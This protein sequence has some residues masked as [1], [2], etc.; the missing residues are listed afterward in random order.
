M[1]PPGGPR[2]VTTA[3]IQA[4][5]PDSLRA[6]PCLRV[7]EMPSLRTY[8]AASAATVALLL[9]ILAAAASI[10]LANLGNRPMHCDEAVHGIKFGQLLEQDTYIYDPHEYHGPSLNYLTLPVAWITGAEEIVDVSEAHLR[11][12]P[13]F[14][15]ILLVGLVWLLRHEMGSVAMLSAA[16]LTAFSPAMVFFSRYYIQEMLLVA[17]T[18]LAIV[19]LGRWAHLLQPRPVEVGG[20]PANSLRALTLPAAGWLALF[21]LAVAMMHASKETCVLALAAMLFAGAVTLPQVRRAGWKRLVPSI[22]FAVAVGAAVSAAFFSS[23]GKNPSG[24]ADSYSTYFHYLGQ[25]SGEGSVGRHVQPWHY[26]F[27]N[28]FWWPAEP[29]RFWSEGL[30]AALAF[31]GMVAAVVGKA[32]DDRQRR[33]ARFLAMYTVLLTVVYAALPYKTPWCSLSFLSGMILLAGVGMAA[34]LKALPNVWWKGLSVVVFVAFLVHLGWQAY[35]A[36]F[37]FYEHRQNPYVY[38]HTTDDVPLLVDCIRELAERHPDGTAMHIQAICPD[39]DYWPLPWYL[40]GFATVA[41]LDAIPAGSPAPLII[42]KPQVEEDLLRYLYVV[43]PPGHR[44][45]YVP[46]PPPEGRQEWMFRPNVPLR[47]YVRLQLWNVQQATEE[48]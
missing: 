25:A 34:M 17:F 39:H 27:R 1:E 19:A 14:F 35:E 12:V 41:W 9:A 29:G 4:K 36:S 21:G 13:A 44:N 37:V 15:G 40:R 48:R 22:L 2:M 11:L 18:L 20:K 23:F 6:R 45:L 24:I 32:F 7:V 43:Q 16:A 8:F 38:S 26:Y 33:F 30:I 5:M 10:R 47:V 46:L 28:L 3:A 42:T 31:A